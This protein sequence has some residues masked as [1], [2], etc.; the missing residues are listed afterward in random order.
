MLHGVGHCLP[1]EETLL[2]RG[3]VYVSVEQRISA[4]NTE[5]RAGKE[6]LET[7]R[8]V[9][10]FYQERYAEICRQEEDIDY[11]K[12]TVRHNYIYKGAEV[13]KSCLQRLKNCQKLHDLM[14]KL[15]DT[16]KMLVKNCGQGEYALLLALVK[17]G[18]QIDACDDDSDNIDTARHC[19]AVPANLHYTT[20]DI[21]ETEYDYVMDMKEL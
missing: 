2:R 4:D 16:G 21:E 13:A 18:W 7:A 5:F 17:K 19:V 8:L 20:E 14:P 1:K 11:Y 6:S 10:H 3:K 12:D 15:A 9:R